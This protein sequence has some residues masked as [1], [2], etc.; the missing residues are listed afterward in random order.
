M[1]TQH[2]QHERDI[3]FEWGMRAKIVEGT[4]FCT[5]GWYGKLLNE[6]LQNPQHQRRLKH[7]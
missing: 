2:K 5:N 7:P 6:S 4:T 3:G 1:Y